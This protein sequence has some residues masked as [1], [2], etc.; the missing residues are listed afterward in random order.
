MF[1]GHEA[2]VRGRRRAALVVAA[3]LSFPLP[4]FAQEEDPMVTD[5][6]D[7]TESAVTVAPGRFQFEL[8]YTFTR[9]G[10]EDRHDF[11]ELLARLGILPWLEGR[12]GLNSL[13]LVTAPSTES[14]GLQDMTVSF[15]ALLFRKPA[16]SSAAVPQVALLVGTDLPTGNDGFGEGE[17]QP[18]AKLAFDFGLSERFGLASNVGWA[19][20]VSDGSRFH[21][22][23]GSVT[24][25]YA[26]SGPLSVYTEWYGFFPENRAGGSRH[27]V[28]GGVAWSLG[29]DTRIDWRIGAGLQESG[30]NWYTGAG[31]SFR[32]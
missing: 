15:K 18:G 8:G 25:G 16:G 21:Q 4:G 1:Q 9:K 11:G 20:L 10:T 32:L 29:P 17:M 22:G 23:V 6:P 3:I 19:Y 13:A 27:Y 12:L 28:D 30:P 2:R 24:L 5:R 31:L 14:S 26:V 7:F